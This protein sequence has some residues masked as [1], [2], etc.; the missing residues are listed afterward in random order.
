MPDYRVYCLNNAGKLA[1][2]ELISAENDEEAVAKAREQKGDARKCEVWC[3]NR[4]VGT[5]GSQLRFD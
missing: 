5:F 4:L 1:F 3:N 2:D